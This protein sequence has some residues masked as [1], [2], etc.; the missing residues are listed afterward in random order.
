MDRLR[1]SADSPTGRGGLGPTHTA[2]DGLY[3]SRGDV[4][5]NRDDQFRIRS[6]RHHFR[7]ADRRH[8]LR[9]DQQALL[10]GDPRRTSFASGRTIGLVAQAA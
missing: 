1:V 9:G 2:S 5:G 4:T 3:P 6:F 10:A 8:S 7:C